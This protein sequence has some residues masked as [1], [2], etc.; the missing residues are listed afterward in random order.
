MTASMRTW[1]KGHRLLEQSRSCPGSSCRA[2]PRQLASNESDLSF[3]AS[4]AAS[5]ALA[6]AWWRDAS[7]TQ[8]DVESPRAAQC[9]A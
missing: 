8:C 3:A 4:G 2:L 9:A 1:T 6:S 5:G 7:R